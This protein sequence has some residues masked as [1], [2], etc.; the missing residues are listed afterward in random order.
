MAVGNVL[1][2]TT[3]VLRQPVDNVYDTVAVPEPAPVVM[4]PVPTPIVATVGLSLSHVP[5]PGVLEIVVVPPWQRLSEP[6]IAP[7]SAFTVTIVVVIHP[8]PSE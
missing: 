7:G 2:V 8:E 1:T 3:A 4:I 6:L 5:P